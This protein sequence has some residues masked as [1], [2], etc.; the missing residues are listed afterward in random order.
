MKIPYPPRLVVFFP[1]GEKFDKQFKKAQDEGNVDKMVKLER[2]RQSIEADIWNSI[3]L[4]QVIRKCGVG[5]V[6]IT[7]MK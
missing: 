5:S 7:F 4:T 3:L 2:E 6:H 1:K